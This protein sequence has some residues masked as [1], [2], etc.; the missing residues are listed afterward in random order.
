MRWMEDKSWGASAEHRA[1][2]IRHYLRAVSA[3]TRLAAFATRL[4]AKSSKACCTTAAPVKA[5]VVLVAMSVAGSARTSPALPPVA[6]RPACPRREAKHHMTYFPNV[7]TGHKY[8]KDR[9]FSSLAGKS[10]LKIALQP[11]DG[12]AQLPHVN[13]IPLF[14]APVLLQLPTWRD[15]LRDRFRA[16]GRNS[17]LVP[18]PRKFPSCTSGYRQSTIVRQTHQHLSSDGGTWVRGTKLNFPGSQWIS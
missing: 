12:R 16:S 3:S 18:L 15:L 14:Q 13:W 10:S 5:A 9:R 7:I 2:G 4:K 17:A 8:H 11:A 6:S 1:A